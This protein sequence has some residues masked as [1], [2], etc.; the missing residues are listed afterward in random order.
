MPGLRLSPTIG[1]GFNGAMPLQAWILEYF[2]ATSP[3]VWEL[4]WGHA[5]SGMDMDVVKVQ[6]I[7]NLPLLQNASAPP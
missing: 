5:L 6:S 7:N 3:E 4:Q 2:L 1:Y